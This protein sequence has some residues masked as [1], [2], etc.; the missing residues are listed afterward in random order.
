M[1]SLANKSY[2]SIVIDDEPISIDVFVNYI[3]RTPNLEMVASFTD[4]EL[5]F[6]YLKNNVKGAGG[7]EID[8]VFLDI[9]M[10]ELDGIDILESLYL[11]GTRFI[12]ATGLSQ[13]AHL[14][15]NFNALDFLHKPFSYERFL[16]AL[17]KYIALL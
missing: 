15:F 11:S 4:S 14:G 9:D 10:P 13:H 2:T 6:K 8:M 5:A 16:K 3:N 7:A 12:L 1:S 17:D